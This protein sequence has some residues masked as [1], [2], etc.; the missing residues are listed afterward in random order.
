MPGIGASYKIG[1]LYTHFATETQV[2]PSLGAG[3]AVLS[4]N[5]DWTYGAYATVVAAGVITD[6]FHPT[7]VNIEACDENAIFQLQLYKG[8]A[9]AV[10]CTVRFAISGGFFGNQVYMVISAPV[11][12]GSQVRARLASSNGAAAQATIAMSICYIEH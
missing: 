11:E 3:T 1:E 6:H 8:A 4:S 5:A 7:H 10:I 9:D 12:G 2:Y